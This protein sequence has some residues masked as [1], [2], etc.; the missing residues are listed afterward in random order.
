MVAV[1][2][3]I[4]LEPKTELPNFQ[5]NSSFRATVVIV[6]QNE[7]G[8]IP[9]SNFV[10]LKTMNG[11]RIFWK[12]FCWKAP[13]KVAPS[14]NRFLNFTLYISFSV[15]AVGIQREKFFPSQKMNCVGIGS[16][17]RIF[18]D[19]L[20]AEKFLISPSCLPLFHCERSSFP[21]LSH[22]H[23]LPRAVLGFHDIF[24]LNRKCWLWWL[25]RKCVSTL[26]EYW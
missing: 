6:N 25:N 22:T 9:I 7:I 1:A 16:N 2:F 11:N 5:F 21:G 17:I 26:F 24:P 14:A 10:V 18:L 15:L 8:S 12:Y 23:W 4:A 19:C 3:L 20:W 13:Q